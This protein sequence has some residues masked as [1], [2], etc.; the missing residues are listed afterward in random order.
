MLTSHSVFMLTGAQIWV[1]CIVIY[2]VFP[3][4][5]GTSHEC[6]LLDGC[7]IKETRQQFLM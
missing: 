1:Y 3:L 4:K 5:K 6:D 7:L 2:V